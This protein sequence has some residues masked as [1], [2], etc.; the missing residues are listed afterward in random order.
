MCLVFV[1]FLMNYIILHISYMYLAEEG[2]IVVTLLRI[3][4][5]KRRLSMF[6]VGRVVGISVAAHAK[7][8][9]PPL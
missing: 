5:M 3:L 6:D 9:T 4:R 2:G 7:C 1:D 8:P